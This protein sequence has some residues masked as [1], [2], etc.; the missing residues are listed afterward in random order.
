MKISEAPAGAQTK[1]VDD[2]LT[3]GVLRQQRSGPY[4]G[5]TMP[6]M[7]FLHRRYRRLG[8]K[9]RSGVCS[10]DPR[11]DWTAKCCYGEARDQL[12]SQDANA[13][14]SRER[15]EKPNRPKFNEA[16]QVVP[17]RKSG[18]PGRLVP[19]GVLHGN[20]PALGPKPSTG[21]N[22]VIH[23]IHQCRRPP[24]VQHP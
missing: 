4:Q 14:A 15:A 23:Q 24:R 5:R 6:Q 18:A 7:R 20:A 1:L 8:L 21:C 3:D 13:A 10:R 12:Q 17:D 2:L 11:L 19:P 22:T 16:D 9:C